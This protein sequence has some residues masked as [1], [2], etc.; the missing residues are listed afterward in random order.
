MRGLPR[1]VLA[2]A[3][4][5]A[6]FVVVPVVAMVARLDV[7]GGLG[8]IW[9][10]LTSPTA[11]DALWL[12]VR[13]SLVAT[14]C[15]VLLGA[16][17]ALVLARTTFPGQRLARALVLLPLVLPPV[18]GGIALL[19]TFG[20]RGLIGQH[21]SVLG[22]E[23]AFTTTAVVMAQTFV[24][25]PFLVLS[26][27][28]SLRTHDARYEEVAAT[29]GATP[30]TV[31]RRVT[32]PLVLPGLAS[33]AVLAFARALGEFGATI[34]FAGALQ[35]VTQTLPLEIY[36]QRSAD[37]D[38]A[39]ALS[40][41]LVVVAVVVTAAV[42]GGPFGRAPST[43]GDRMP[44]E[45]DRS[46]EGDDEDP[47]E[48]G[49]RDRRQAGASPPASGPGRSGEPGGPGAPL[50]VRVRLAERG[51]DVDVT[52]EPGQVVA[53]LGANGAGKSTLLQAVTGLLPHRARPRSGSPDELHVSIDGTVLTDTTRGTAVPPR[54]RRVG[55]LTQRPLLLAH[56]DAVDDVAFGLRARGA[57]RREARAQARE[58]L[59]DLDAEHLAE[60]RPRELSG[61]QAQR[62]SIAR[63]LATD[64]RVLLLDEPLASLDVGVA[65]QVRR[66]LHDAQRTRPRT[67]LLVT[68]DLLD[69]LLLADRAV[70][71][72]H[73]RVVED[74]P[75]REVLSRPRSRFAARLAGI[76]LL[77]GTA[78]DDGGLRL[79]AGG[80]AAP[81]LAGSASG[82]GALATTPRVVAGVVA[83]GAG[84]VEG[85]PAVAMFEPRAVA[86]HRQA[87]SGSPRNAFAVTITSLEPH[88]QL[89][90]AWGEATGPQAVRDAVGHLA[91]DLT[92]RS[93]AD[94][95]L[96]P[97]ERVWFAVKAAEV[98][99]YSTR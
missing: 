86:V 38:A 6:L 40:L 12:S 98:Q 46:T 21:L 88:G 69:V 73:G 36:L 72:E 82:T 58:R 19:Y 29:L 7:S 37:P 28:G 4:L 71:L 24:A 64:P 48:A 42:H 90:R 92:P 52:V 76:N 67:T 59:R 68:H 89:F 41:L 56:L 49:S 43:D 11:T 62:V 25:L 65:Q 17:M 5:G 47:A 96:A 83:D 95:R 3:I 66:A 13:T 60:R 35:G 44:A 2:P 14:V 54:R 93:V 55:W 74:G 75:A 78:T 84:L 53:V 20:R 30:T 10:L 39:V 33:G 70:V 31:L 22:I 45:P 87:P 80:D 8:G 34:T 91:A 26:L 97:G 94:L 9:D 61:G 27:E 18:V 81:A 57:T 77:S 79:G 50:R 85:D 63:A 15:C 1:W 23:V 51:V 16:P 32:L 99:V